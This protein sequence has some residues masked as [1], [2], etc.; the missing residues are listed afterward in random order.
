MTR[1]VKISLALVAVFVAVAVAVS[2]LA[3]GEDESPS[4]ASTTATTATT[5]TEST[6]TAR[7]GQE[8]PPDAARAVRPSSRVLGERGSSGVTFTEFLDF[9]CEACAAAYPAIEQLREEYEGRVTFVIR[10]FPIPSHRNAL[11]AALAVEAAAQQGAL[12]PMYRRMYETQQQ[13]GEQQTS[14]APL[15]RSWARDLG[16]DMAAY[17]AAVEDPKTRRRI[18]FDVREGQRLGVT[19]TPTFFLGDELIEPQSLDDLRARLDA[20]IGAR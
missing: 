13:W 7:S 12:E 6:T 18:A 3:G 9:E 20:A 11:N 15:F 14:K 1:N 17:D 4:S 5:T 19:G 16:L 10:Y 8:R 2:L